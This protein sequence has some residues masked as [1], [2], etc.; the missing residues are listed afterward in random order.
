[1]ANFQVQGPCGIVSTELTTFHNHLED[2]ALAK[3]SIAEESEGFAD[4]NRGEKGA[5]RA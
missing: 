4:Y 5:R 2:V 1:M 3:V